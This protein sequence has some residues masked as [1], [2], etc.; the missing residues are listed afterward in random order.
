LYIGII[1]SATLI[2]SVVFTLIASFY[3]DRLGR[4]KVLI[5]YSALM[6]ISGLVFF[7]TSNYMALIVSAF[8]GTINVTGTET[9]AFLSIEQ[10]MLP[11]T[12][13]DPKKR[14]T[15]YALYNM[16]GTFAMSAGV[17]LSGLPHVFAQQYDWNQIESIKPLFVLYSTIGLGALGIYFLISSRVELYW[18]T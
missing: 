18:L 11:Q 12:I 6:S 9:G 13:D 14:N 10:A 8:I 3:A 7:V 15:V 17:L 1:L 16:A 2:N 4:R 5:V